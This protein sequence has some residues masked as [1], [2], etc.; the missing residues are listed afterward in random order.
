MWNSGAFTDVLTIG[1][2]GPNIHWSDTPGLDGR[3]W[4]GDSKEYMIRVPS[5][6]IV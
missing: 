6:V 2:L 5:I 1:E 4:N 3:Y